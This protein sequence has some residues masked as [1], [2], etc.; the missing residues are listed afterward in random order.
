MESEP[1]KLTIKLNYHKHQECP[2]IVNLIFQEKGED[3]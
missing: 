3:F 1:S 2:K